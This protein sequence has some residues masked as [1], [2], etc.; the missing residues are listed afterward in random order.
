MRNLVPRACGIDDRRRAQDHRAL[1]R[2]SM[3]LAPTRMPLELP[4]LYG[5]MYRG[6]S[7]T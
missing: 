3:W 2:F 4:V 6:T 5:R 1:F 7:A